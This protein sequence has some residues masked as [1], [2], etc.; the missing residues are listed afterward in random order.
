[1]PFADL[2]PE[3]ERNFRRQGVTSF[4]LQELNKGYYVAGR[5]LA[6]R[7]GPRN[8]GS[9]AALRK[10]GLRECGFMLTGTLALFETR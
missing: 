6:A 2:Y 5:L 10:A 9:R 7:R 4:L 8:V 3:V 1:M